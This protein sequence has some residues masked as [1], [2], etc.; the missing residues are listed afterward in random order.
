MTTSAGIQRLQYYC[1]MREAYS[2]NGL[3]F[4]L[5]VSRVSYKLLCEVR[6]GMH[7]AHT[8]THLQ[9][10]VYID[11]HTHTH[12]QRHRLFVHFLIVIIIVL[13]FVYGKGTKKSSYSLLTS[14]IYSL[15]YLPTYFAYL[16]LLT[17]LL[18]C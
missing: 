10:H 1:K 12:S 3:Q 7:I 14:L 8:H 2:T 13:H 9:R 11:I 16:G 4:L 18:M 6:S 15:P 17:Y 5:T